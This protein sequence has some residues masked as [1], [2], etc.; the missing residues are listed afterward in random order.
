MAPHHDPRLPVRA[1]RPELSFDQQRRE[2]TSTE[3]WQQLAADQPWTASRR[4]R[5]LLDFLQAKLQAPGEQLQ[6]E[7]AEGMWELAVNKEH[8]ADML[9]REAL[10][11]LVERLASP[12]LEVARAAAAAAWG[13][14]V[15][16]DARRA[17]QGLGAVEVLAGAARRSLAIEGCADADGVPLDKYGGEERPTLSQRQRFQV[18]SVFACLCMSGCVR[19]FFCGVCID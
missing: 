18:K 8:H 15:S 9:S 6:L 10:G 7:G 1:G 19:C 16:E 12:N 17:L 5:L 11:A 3:E 4:R 14:A 13:L 2:V